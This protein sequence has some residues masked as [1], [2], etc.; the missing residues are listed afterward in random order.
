M[1]MEIRMYKKLFITY[2]L[3]YRTF[4]LNPELLLDD[5][6]NHGTMDV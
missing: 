5:H 3:I 1:M 4:G 2:F 6:E